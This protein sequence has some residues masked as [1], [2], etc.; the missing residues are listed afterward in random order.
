M[1]KFPAV[2]EAEGVEPSSGNK[3][4]VNDGESFMNLHSFLG[5]RYEKDLRLTFHPTLA[6]GLLQLQ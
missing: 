3:S 2:L 1:S 4:G 5:E 6:D